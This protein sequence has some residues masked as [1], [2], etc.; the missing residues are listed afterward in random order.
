MSLTKLYINKIFDVEADQANVESFAEV[1]RIILLDQK[2]PA[3][4][5]A[6][7]EIAH[8][9]GAKKTAV[10]F[11]QPFSS[12]IDLK[13]NK[14]TAQY[15]ISLKQA[16]SVNQ[17]TL[18][19]HNFGENCY[20]KVNELKIFDGTLKEVPTFE[21]G[22]MIVQEASTRMA[23]NQYARTIRWLFPATNVSQIILELEQTNYYPVRYSLACYC[24]Y[25]NVAGNIDTSANPS[26]AKLIDISCKTLFNDI[27][28]SFG[29]EALTNIEAVNTALD[30]S[31]AE[32]A[33]Y[34]DFY[35]NY[36]L[37]LPPGAFG[38]LAPLPEFRLNADVGQE[39]IFTVPR[40][41]SN[42]YRYAIGIA[43]INLG[44]MNYDS[45]SI[46]I[47]KPHKIEKLNEI[48]VEV[49]D[50]MP[51]EFGIGEW[52]KYYISFDNGISYVRINPINYN[53]VKFTDGLVIPKT[54][55]YN[56]NIPDEYKNRNPSGIHAYYDSTSKIEN[57]RLKVE[58]FRPSGPEYKSFSPILYSYM[59]KIK[60]AR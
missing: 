19:S 12:A 45:A 22:A 40:E 42:R 56:S 60:L 9:I 21:K 33:K 27:V 54:I 24:P 29:P 32:L 11:Q 20:L 49:N 6:K 17:I 15:V 3:I 5:R 1:E 50:F 26:E 31:I 13:N 39:G 23:D 59:L 18:T 34:Y 44:L 28:K 4:E 57:I 8:K 35:T 46:F 14:L 30:F 25:Y 47:S 36:G 43:D 51:I 16:K 58:L 52:M 7:N 37:S 10:L 55:Y 38:K 48:S 41:E 2:I 53:D